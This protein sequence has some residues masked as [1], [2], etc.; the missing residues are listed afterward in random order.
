MESVVSAATG[1]GQTMLSRDT[2]RP[3]EKGSLWE[4]HELTVS[5]V[6]PCR[7]VARRPNDP[8]RM[9][10]PASMRGGASRWRQRRVLAHCLLL[11][12]TAVQNNR[13]KPRKQMDVV[14]RVVVGQGGRT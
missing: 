2:G 3:P 7:R 9:H 4:S 12:S 1:V 14:L 10:F 8:R 13:R 6:L 5:R 11:P